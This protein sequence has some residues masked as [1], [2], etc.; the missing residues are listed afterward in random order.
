MG[1]K[2]MAGSDT[3]TLTD[4][5]KAAQIEVDQ[6]K[7]QLSNI[8]SFRI[9]YDL[10]RLQQ[11]KHYTKLISE[12]NEKDEADRDAEKL[13]LW[14]KKRDSNENPLNGTQWNEMK[15][16]L[17]L[18]SPLEQGQF[19][20]LMSAKVSSDEEEGLIGFD[21]NEMISPSTWALLWQYRQD[22]T[23]SYKMGRE[24][25]F[26]IDGKILN[27]P[28]DLADPPPEVYAGDI[29]NMIKF[30]EL[31]IAEFSDQIT[32]EDEKINQWNNINPDGTSGGD[33]EG[34][35]KF[36]Q[37]YYNYKIGLLTSQIAAQ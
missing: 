9:I 10:Y 6:K 12:E 13:E 22:A 16:L 20:K 11:F 19:V 21:D 27:L 4:E 14:E 25:K 1:I 29:A 26:L 28:Q 8:L 36:S 18:I 3:T 2:K 37:T 15:T 24:D 17:H 34:A 23:I 33:G 7:T 35:V 31:N 30:F 32:D 5:Q